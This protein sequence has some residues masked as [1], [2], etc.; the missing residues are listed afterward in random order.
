[1]LSA[2]ERAGTILGLYAFCMVY[3]IPVYPH[4]ASANEFSRWVTVAGVVEHRSFDVR[5]AAP[6]IGVLV[7]ASRSGVHLY[8]NK[9]PGLA[10]LSAPGYLLGRVLFGPPS[11]RNLRPSLYLMR[12]AGVTLPVLALGWLWWRDDEADPLALATLLFATPLFIYGALLFSHAVAAVLL[13]AAYRLLFPREDCAPPA[14][15]RDFAAGV[16][17][18]L[19]TVTEYPCALVTALFGVALLFSPGRGRRIPRFIAGGV[20]FAL[21]LAL[22][23]RLL[24]GSALSLSS[25]H[26]ASANTAAI[27]A[28]GLLGIGWPTMHGIFILF[29]SPSRGL[30]FYSPILIFGLVALWPIHGRPG[31]V[32]SWVRFAVVLTWFAAIAGYPADAG[33]WCVGARYLVAM[34]PFLVEA[35]RD[36]RVQARFGASLTLA[37]SLVLCALPLLTFPFPDPE[38]HH[39]HADFTR[40]LLAAGFITPSF[41]S[42]ITPAWPSLLPVIVAAAAALALGLWGGGKRAAAGAALGLVLAAGVVFVP[43]PSVKGHVLLRDLILEAHYKPEGRLF[44][45]AAQ[46]RD[47]HFAAFA[48]QVEMS[49]LA[50]RQ[51]GPD[52]W[53]YSKTGGENRP[54]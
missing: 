40:P 27:A 30:F 51:R 23:N 50:A 33:G 11:F 13:Y 49:A 14:G 38:F 4:F 41:G 1:M 3:L 37:F 16:L 45:L 48:D 28:R 32:R 20:P 52:N 53:P 42:W 18:G 21:L 35:A 25:A 31:N 10:L 47:R 9:A 12:V 15:W 34:L 24:F 22:Y 19:G 46:S 26:E 43:L 29:L 7:D 36:R 39:V 44:R 8:S 6:L 54:N 2:R 17:C 5:W